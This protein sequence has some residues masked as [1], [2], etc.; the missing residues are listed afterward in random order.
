LDLIHRTDCKSNAKTI[1]TVSMS[2]EYFYFIGNNTSDIMAQYR[3]P[4]LPWPIEMILSVS[5]DY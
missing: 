1:A 2:F 3:L 5:R 4:Y